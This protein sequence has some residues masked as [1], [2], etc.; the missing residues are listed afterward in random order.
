[1]AYKLTGRLLLY[2]LLTITVAYTVLLF[3]TFKSARDKTFSRMGA[4]YK[5]A[6]KTPEKTTVTRVEVHERKM[7]QLPAPIAPPAPI[8][9]YPPRRTL[10]ADQSKPVL[11][12]PVKRPAREVEETVT[13]TRE[14]PSKP[15]AAA[16]Q[17]PEA[18]PPPRPAKGKEQ[19]AAFKNLIEGNQSI[20]SLVNQSDPKLKFK[21]WTAV[22]SEGDE[23][24][25]DVVFQNT[26]DQSEV[27]Y[28]WSVNNT[29]KKIIPLNHYAKKLAAK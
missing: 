24:W 18:A 15:L 26:A 3:A 20:A 2:T 23:H 17:K 1:M 8:S 16:E 19:E 12:Q 6:L 29:S 7:A 5:A 10:K 14:E 21:T 28:T 25:I 22:K 11:T 9:V 27:H 4:L 13:E